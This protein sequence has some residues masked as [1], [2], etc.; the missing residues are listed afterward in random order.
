M[1]WLWNLIAVALVLIF[2]YSLY[3]SY[4]IK[5][6][7]WVALETISLALVIFALATSRS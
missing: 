1:S 5:K 2:G 6:Y 3:Q 4:R 7:G